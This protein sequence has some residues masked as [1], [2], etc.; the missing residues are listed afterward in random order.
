MLTD[1]C[2]EDFLSQGGN[3]DCQ[4]HASEE[5]LISKQ[6]V[7]RLFVKYLLLEENFWQYRLIVLDVDRLVYP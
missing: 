7:H 2:K 1:S 3:F 6:R 4:W 5:C